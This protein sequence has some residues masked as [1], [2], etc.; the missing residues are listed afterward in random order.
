MQ[1]VTGHRI[2][3][4]ARSNQATI[5]GPICKQC[6]TEIAM[7]HAVHWLATSGSLGAFTLTNRT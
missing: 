7:K 1:D 5:W 4:E 2:P 6:L 3:E